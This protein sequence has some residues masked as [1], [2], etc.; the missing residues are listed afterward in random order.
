MCLFTVC[1]LFP[2]ASISSQSDNEIKISKQKSQNHNRLLS[3]TLRETTAAPGSVHP[4]TSTPQ[5]RITGADGRAGPVAVPNPRT[6]SI[7]VSECEV[8]KHIKVQQLLQQEACF[9]HNSCQTFYYFAV[10]IL[11]LCLF[12]ICSYGLTVCR[13]GT[14]CCDLGCCLFRQ[15][16]I[17]GKSQLL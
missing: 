8:Q 17:T 10:Y 13:G 9:K 7:I 4:N 1:V 5:A 3:E 15:V 16:S 12:F 11:S 6:D 2:A 14:C